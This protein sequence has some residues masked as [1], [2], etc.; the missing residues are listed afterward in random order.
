MTR[1]RI[2]LVDDD[3]RILE[4]YQRLL[5]LLNYEIVIAKNGEEALAKY[6]ETKPGIVM[7]DFKMP[8]MS[9]LEVTRALHARDPDADVILVTGHSDINTVIRALRHGVSDFVPKPVNDTALEA[10]LRRAERRI[11]LKRELRA[12]QEAL[13]RSEREKSLILNSTQELFMYCT[14][15]LKIQWVNRAAAESVGLEPADLVG[16]HCYTMWLQ[17]YEPCEVCPVLLALETGEDQEMEV[18]TPDGRVWFVRGYP[19]RD[20]AGEIVGLVELTQDITRRRRAEIAAQR[21]EARYRRMFEGAA[22]SLWEEDITEL[23][24]A[25]QDLQAQGV[26]DLDAYM[27]AHPDF[28]ERAIALIQVLNVNSRTLELYGAAS[29]DELLGSL[30]KS[31]VRDALDDFRAELLIIADPAGG[32]FEKE[33][34]AKTLQ[35]ETLHI[36]LRI[37]I[38]PITDPVPTMLVS[39]TDITARKRAEAALQRAH[40]ELELRV[41]NRTVEL[42]R[43]NRQLEE[44]IVERERA[45]ASL[46]RFAD[47]QATLY[48]ITAAAAQFLERDELLHATL[49]AV[50]PT[51]RADG[52]WITLTEHPAEPNPDIAA[53]SGLDAAFVAAYAH[54]DLSECPWN[55]DDTVP[56]IAPWQAE[57][58][59]H[60]PTALLEEHGLSAHHCVPLYAGSQVLGVLNLVWRSPPQTP[61][62]PD[63][64][65]AIGQQVGIALHNAQLYAAAR[66]VNRLRILNAIASAAISS[67]DLDIVLREALVLICEALDAEEGSILLRDEDTGALV[68]AQTL[69]PAE[70]LVLGQR[71]AP[72]QGIAGWVAERGESLRV[73][74]VQEESRWF[75]G[76]DEATGFVTRSLLCVPL[77]YRDQVTGVLEVVNKRAGRFSDEDLHLLEAA[78]ASAAAA[79]DNA[80]LFADTLQRA[81]EMAR[82]NEIGVVLAAS[83]DIDEVVE[84]AL[85]RIQ[86]FFA[87]DGVLLLQVEHPSDTIPRLAYAGLD[88]QIIDISEVFPL[89]NDFNQTLMQQHQPALIAD[90]QV[91]TRWPPA[92]NDYAIHYMG[93]PV[94]AV[95]V[96]PLQVRDRVIGTFTVASDTPHAYSED[97]VQTL[98]TLSVTLAVALDNA[99]LYRELKASLQQQQETQDRLIHT[100]K[101]A[102][103]GRLAASIAHEINN[104]LQAVEGYLEMSREKLR[105]P[106]QQARIAGYL[107]VTI[108]EIERI[109]DIVRQMHEFYRPIRDGLGSIDIHAILESVLTLS[110][111]QLEHSHVTVIRR[112]DA[113]HAIVAGNADQLKQVFLNLVLNAID[114]M[115]DGGNLHI[116]TQADTLPEF[117]GMG[118]GP[119]LCI[120]FT[121]SGAGI[122]ADVLPHIFEPFF[123]TKGSGTGL[124]LSISYGIIES[125]SGEMSVESAV[126]AGTTFTIRLPVVE[127]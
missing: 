100:E 77:I 58:C 62:N 107:D 121:D 69:S 76:V 79:I 8:G 35:G 18:T 63:L 1:E 94:R 80:R 111:K 39:V 48:A 81:D 84:T 41:Q 72:G 106:D 70:G 102:A 5:G 44:E 31:S 124:G 56:K 2:L 17:R 16:Q 109:S 26:T 71:I 27:K 91:D 110:A 19:V 116:R 88:E 29:K 30:A 43:A 114:A 55:A 115:P 118:T 10:A 52:G 57:L 7:I 97:D 73:N 99:R 54:I 61:P 28:V 14:P 24:A 98:Q 53:H 13:R 87:A 90:T 12:A 37:T 33:T 15:D 20:E 74:D 40:D 36:L 112:W 123:T 108:G 34:R 113:E 22:V 32:I 49:D 9:G 68:F 23:R 51:L 59:T 119:A 120:T 60:I 127:T 82:I 96:M 66:Q 47:E 6:A 126:N 64:L 25:L 3:P 38:P 86:R 125:H 122:S 78:A 21:S 93:R 11:H 105:R 65:L 117:R 85:H 92:Y 95:M 103:L 104:P 101:M 50:V 4:A 89:N 67:L 46:R 42:T 83:L 75:A 45:E